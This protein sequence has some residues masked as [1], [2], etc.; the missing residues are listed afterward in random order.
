M[1]TGEAFAL[2]DDKIRAGFLALA[3]LAQSPQTLVNQLGWI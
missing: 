2:S 1:T 3:T